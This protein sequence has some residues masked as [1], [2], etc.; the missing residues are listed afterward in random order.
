MTMSATIESLGLADQIRSELDF[1]RLVEGG[2]PLE[3]IGELR[4]LGD[5]SDAEL[6]QIIPRRSLAHA[7]T[8][9]QLSPDQSDRIARAAGIFALAHATFLS[10][11][12]GNDWLRQPNG[13]LG[14]QVPL[15]LIRTGSG[16]ELVRSVL[17][18]IAYGVYD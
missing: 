6:A 3:T 15:S 5:L 4:Q 11:S 16:A 10:A 13:V 8:R 14:G 18:R 17:G 1:V 7:R 2:F 9:R 12:K